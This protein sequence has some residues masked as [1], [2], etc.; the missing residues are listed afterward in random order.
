MGMKM[1]IKANLVFEY[2]ALFVIKNKYNYKRFTT[3]IGES[4]GRLASLKFTMYEINKFVAYIDNQIG[5]T[6]DGFIESVIDQEL[7]YVLNYG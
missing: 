4:A 7:N 1:E 2:M 3:S 5:E 6:K